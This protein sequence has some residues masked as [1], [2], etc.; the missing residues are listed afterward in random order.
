MAT[1]AK[2]QPKQQQELFVLAPASVPQQQFLASDSTITLYHGSAGGGKTFA[3][4]LNMIK[5]AAMQNSTI[6][7]FRK[8]STQIKS[9][10]GIWQEAVPIFTKMFPDA[11]VRH[12][13][14]EIYIP[15]TNS[16]VKFSHLQHISDVYNHL[17]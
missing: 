9:G 6:V 8:N 17:G 4:I 15:S 11:R 3:I 2:K 5:F 16:Y 12:R 1:K 13:D 14:L 7:L 10:G